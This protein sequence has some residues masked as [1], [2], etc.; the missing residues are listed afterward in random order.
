MVKL[1]VYCQ[2]VMG[3]LVG[4]EWKPMRQ[5][6]WRTPHSAL[7]VISIAKI[8]ACVAY[9]L[10]LVVTGIASKWMIELLGIR[11]WMRIVRMWTCQSDTKSIL[12]GP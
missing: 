9:R 8:V 11:R 2:P 10:E 3:L 5:F 6:S 12:V 1:S 7:D 4:A